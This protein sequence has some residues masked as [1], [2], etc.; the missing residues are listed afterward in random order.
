MTLDAEETA[1]NVSA[2]LT[3]EF[4]NLVQID[5]AATYTRLSELQQSY[6]AAMTVGAAS[7]SGRLFDLL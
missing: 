4:N 7:S 2:I 1:G 5:E 6:N 3:G